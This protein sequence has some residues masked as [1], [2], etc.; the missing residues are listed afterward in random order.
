M[1]TR[2]NVVY[3]LLSVIKSRVGVVA[4]GE[5]DG[6]T[7][8]HKKNG[9]FSIVKQKKKRKM[10]VN[11]ILHYSSGTCTYKLFTDSVHGRVRITQYHAIVTLPDINI[12]QPYNFLLFYRF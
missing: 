8:E 3:I 10:F 2:Y 5:V 12:A 6:R 9:S 1:C 7:R 11:I 4:R